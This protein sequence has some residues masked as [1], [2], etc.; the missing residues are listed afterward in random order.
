MPKS[1]T[2]ILNFAALTNGT[3]HLICILVTIVMLKNEIG[4]N[5][6]VEGNTHFRILKI[7]TNFLVNIVAPFIGAMLLFSD[8]PNVVIMSVVF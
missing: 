3:D 5:A 7:H 4:F 6:Q 1:A 8:Y 2:S